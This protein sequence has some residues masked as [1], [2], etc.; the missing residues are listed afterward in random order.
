[1]GLDTKRSK[2]GREERRIS[3][4][5]L[6]EIPRSRSDAGE[7]YT[8]PENRNILTSDGRV[9]GCGQFDLSRSDVDSLR[10]VSDVEYALA[11]F[12]RRRDDIDASLA[13]ERRR[14]ERERREEEADRR[15]RAARRAE[16]RARKERARSERAE[17]RRRQEQEARSEYERELAEL[18]EARATRRRALVNKMRLRV[19]LFE[20][21]IAGVPEGTIRGFLE[22][23]GVDYSLFDEDDRDFAGSYSDFRARFDFGGDGED[24]DEVAYLEAAETLGV[25]ADADEGTIRSAYR[26]LALAYHPDKWRSDAD[27]GLSREEAMERFRRVQDAYDQLMTKFDDESEFSE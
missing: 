10:T 3:P 25:E 7:R 22:V 24:D 11:L 14:E 20:A 19:L 23:N 5:H 27:H 13:K 4:E 8:V 15:R 21:A 9:L 26:R 17:A 1:M 12:R 16:D 18:Q 2:K 6:E